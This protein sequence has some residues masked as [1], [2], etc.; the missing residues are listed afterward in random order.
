MGVLIL[1]LPFTN[2]VILQRSHGIGV[3]SQEDHKA[4]KSLV[5]WE[6]LVWLW[7]LPPKSQNPNQKIKF[8]N[9]LFLK[10]NFLAVQN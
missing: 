1:L 6:C 9:Q 2:N 10:D 3:L 8:R 4:I 5:G 7:L